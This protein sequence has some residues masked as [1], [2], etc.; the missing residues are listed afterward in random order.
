V[1]SAWRA[2]VELH[3]QQLTRRLISTGGVAYD[4]PMAT[5]KPWATGPYELLRHAELHRNDG[6]DFDRRMAMISYDNAIELS[7][8]TYLG[9]DP[10]QR[11]R[12]SFPREQV[13]KWLHS[14]HTKLEFLEHY[15]VNLLGQTM[16]YAREEII[17]YHRIRNDLYHA[18][19]VMVPR[20]LDV[21]AIREVAIWVFSSLYGVDADELLRAEAAGEPVEAPATREAAPEDQVLAVLLELRK[22]IAQLQQVSGVASRVSD[23]QL[24]DNLL[25]ADQSTASEPLKEALRRANE[26][27]AK[28]TAAKPFTAS[29][30][31]LDKLIVLLQQLKRRVEVPLK[32]HQQELVQRSLD[33]TLLAI[34]SQRHSVGTVYQSTGSGLTTTMLAYLSLVCEHDSLHEFTILVVADRRLFVDQI[35]EQI[36]QGDWLHSRRVLRPS[37]QALGTELCRNTGSIIL[38]TVQALRPHAAAA[39]LSPRTLIVGFDL[40]L[41][42]G[43]ATLQMLKES[44]TIHFTHRLRRAGMQENIIGEYSLEQAQA[45]KVL[46]PLNLEMRDVLGSELLLT[47]ADPPLFDE[48]APLAAQGYEWSESRLRAIAEDLAEHFTTRLEEGSKALVLV[49][50]LADAARLAA[51]LR[52]EFFEKNGWPDESVAVL[53]SAVEPEEVA[54]VVGE[55]CSPDSGVSILFCGRFWVGVDLGVARC[56]YLAC[57]LSASDLRMLAGQLTTPRPGKESALIVDYVGSALD[58]LATSEDDNS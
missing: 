18:N 43:S 4:W 31:E 44:Y 17:Y 30:A 26:I 8:T 56:A 14:Y 3:S 40:Q 9:L 53:T 41:L 58:V 21:G 1:P 29:R 35:H 47:F 51:V 11:A 42:E 25:R 50:K 39:V 33:A 12:R 15:V 2:L 34:A 22:D 55:F 10:T 20:A 24:V 46:V 5:L 38:T 36:S 6:E 52:H 37:R 45:D 19:G 13:D 28:L 57:K 16:R 32:A 27:A 7:I 49:S 23:E 54:R 48:E